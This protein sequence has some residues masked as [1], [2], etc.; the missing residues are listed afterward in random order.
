MRAMTT[1]A[2]PREG[3]EGEPTRSVGELAR[4]ALGA[5]TP[6][7][8]RVART[9]LAAYPMAGLD[10]VV[11]LARRARVSAP[12]VIRFT[13]KLGFATYA[14][15]Q[16]ALKEELEVR[17]SS[18]L[19]QYRA[20]SEV[21]ASGVAADAEG[22]GAASVL[23]SAIQTFKAGIE[24][25]FAA[26][27]KS[28]FDAAV[29]LL[30]DGRRPVLAIGGRFSG[31]LAAYL[32]AHLQQLRPGA[33]HVHEG[34]T[35]QVGELLDVGRRHVL[36]AFDYRRYQRDTVEFAR[37]A[38]EQGATVVLFTDPWLSPIA[39]VAD[40]VLPAGVEAPSPYDSLVAPLAL[41]EAVVAGVVA[42]L[43]DRPRPRIERFDRLTRN[44]VWGQP[45]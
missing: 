10:T 27:P 11:E 40:L 38:A 14:D 5:L 31:M 25:T 17:L 35:G 44:V 13:A 15:F 2:R 24:R 26:L 30:A 36:V 1:G 23:E 32:V 9:L 19:T 42:R 45:I 34:L 41:V 33:S 43:G 21:R 16:R 29:D 4:E 8:R 7:E 3:E 12:T 20:W 39:D 37:R 22:G 6:A 18:P 28:E